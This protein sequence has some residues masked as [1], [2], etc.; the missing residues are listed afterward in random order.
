MSIVRS[1]VKMI[2][3]KRFQDLRAQE[4][5][6]IAAIKAT[7]KL[8]GNQRSEGIVRGFT[9][10]Q[11]EPESVAGTGTGPTPTDFL[12]SSVAFCGNVVF[13]RTAVLNDLDIQAVE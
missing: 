8:I 10:I 3:T 12:I 7:T 5:E 13:A 6:A 2:F 4:T 9:F 11:D 1:V